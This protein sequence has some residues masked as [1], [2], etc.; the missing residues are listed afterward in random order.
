MRVA[1]DT[2]I[3]ISLLRGEPK[4]SARKIA[5]VLTEL[6]QPRATVDFSLCLV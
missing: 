1:L 2:N 5:D 4:P 6:R 3:L